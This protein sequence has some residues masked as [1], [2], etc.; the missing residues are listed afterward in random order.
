MSQGANDAPWLLC[1]ATLMSRLLDGLGERELRFLLAAIQIAA[2]IEGDIVPSSPFDRVARV[3]R[4][5]LVVIPGMH[6]EDVHSQKVYQL[7]PDS[8]ADSV[9][10]PVTNGISLHPD[11]DQVV[12]NHLHVPGLH[13]FW[14]VPRNGEL[15]SQPLHHG[16]EAVN[17]DR[18]EYSGHQ[19]SGLVAGPRGLLGGGF[20][21]RPR[22]LHQ[23]GKKVELGRRDSQNEPNQLGQHGFRLL[24]GEQNTSMNNS[25]HYIKY[26]IF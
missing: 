20:I 21:Q 23:T 22:V 18:H 6:I 25:T 24:K 8:R 17:Q 26:S 2:V 15:V 5:V 1:F 19:P 16:D 4:A 12:E 10:V 3:L 13:P 14:L 9:E 7:L 11:E